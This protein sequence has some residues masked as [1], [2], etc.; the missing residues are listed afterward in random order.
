[1]LCDDSLMNHFG[2]FTTPQKDALFPLKVSNEEILLL[3]AP[4]FSSLLYRGENSNNRPICKPTLFRNLKVEEM[5][6]NKSKNCN[7][8]KAEIKFTG[9]DGRKAQ[10]S[11]DDFEKSLKKLFK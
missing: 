6:P 7:W 8:C 3:P 11:L 1:M 4:E 10:K 2:Y 5:V 9:V